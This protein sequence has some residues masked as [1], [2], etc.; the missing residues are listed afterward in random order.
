LILLWFILRIETPRT[1]VIQGLKDFDWVGTLAMVGG[2]ICF[3]CGLEGGASKLH[4]WSS[5]YTLCLILSGIALLVAFVVWETYFARFPL[6]PMQ[7]FLGTS[8]I[9][10]MACGSFHAFVFITYDY[11]LPLYYQV[12]L[13]K[14][15]I[16]SG[17]YL[18]A[19]IIPLSILS[20]A[21][22]W[23]IKKTGNYHYTAWLGSVVMTIG[24]GL[25]IDFGPSKQLWKI[26]VYQMI[27]G[28]GAGLLFLSPMIALQNHLS[29]ED[30]AMGTSALTSLRT[31]ASTLS[32]VIGGVVLQKNLNGQSLTDVKPEKS[33]GHGGGQ[34]IDQT[35]RQYM[36][37]LDTMWIFYTAM[38]GLVFISSLMVQ[39]PKGKVAP[40]NSPSPEQ[41]EER[42]REAKTG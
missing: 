32:I 41:V 23:Y 31:I 35:L 10:A 33:S 14:T 39:K 37:A 2:V 30:T 18:F 4:S 9:A 27:A 12:V 16:Q 19:L 24:T 11:F 36:K 21:T 28:F 25:F 13:K 15:P 40:P 26:M 6:L 1:S 8:N 22:G 29:K 38:C 7:V 20:A 17:V 3:L 34:G 5:V 42:E